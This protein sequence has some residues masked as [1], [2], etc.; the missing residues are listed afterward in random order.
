[1]KISDTLNVSAEDYFNVLQQYLLKDLRKT[2][3]KSL[4]KSDL[5]AGYQFKKTYRTK[6]GEY[7][8]KQEIVEMDYGKAYQLK[9]TI[10]GGYQIISH[11]IEKIDEQHIKVEYEEVIESHQL[12]IRLRQFMRRGKSRKLMKSILYNLELEIKTK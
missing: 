1:M 10:P 2:V 3:S 9:F 4:K 8:S 12:S 7:E 5:K 6:D 11:H